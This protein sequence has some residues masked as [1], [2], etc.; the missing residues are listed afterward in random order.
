MPNEKPLED[1][2][3]EET[4]LDKHFIAASI[5]GCLEC[6]R[7]NL[8]QPKSKRDYPLSRG[9]LGHAYLLVG[10]VEHYEKTQLVQTRRILD[11]YKRQI[12]EQPKKH[13]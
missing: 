12:Y 3:K 1:L 13:R 2:V 5:R 9:E 10:A 4:L 6:V 11:F 8:A 7:Q